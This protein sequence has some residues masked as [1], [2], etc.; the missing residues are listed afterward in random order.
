MKKHLLLF[1]IIIVL[2]LCVRMCE[3]AIP[4]IIVDDANKNKQVRAVAVI[5][6]GGTHTGTVE[7]PLRIKLSDQTG[8][9]AFGELLVANLHPLF[10]GSF[11]YTVDNTDLNTNLTRNSGSVTQLSGMASIGT[12]ITADSTALLRSKQHG[13]YRA[14]LGGVARFTALFGTPTASTEQH[15]GIIDATSTTAT[16]INGYA[17]G[18]TGTTFGFRRWQ[19]SATTTVTQANWD[20]PLDGSGNSGMTI[21]QT[22][23]NVFFI[24]YQYLGA[25]AIRLFVEDDDTGFLVLVHTIDYANKNTEPSVHNPN[26]FMT[27][28]VSNVGTT[29]DITVRSSSYMYAVEGKTKFIEIHQTS[30]ST[31]LRQKTTVTSEIALFTIRNRATFAGKTN[32]IDI[33]LKHMSASTQANAANARGS[34]RLVKNATLGGSPDYNK[35]STD[36]SVIEIDV[37]G[38]TVTDGINIIPISL[39]GR[40]AAGS[41]LLAPLEIILNPNDTITFA[42]QS[43]NSSTME[44]EL[45]WRELWYYQEWLRQLE[46]SWL[47]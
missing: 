44:G 5:D 29:S 42:V 45:L 26:F 38:T 36:T 30:N 6:E 34:A 23:L 25:G 43:S 13:R 21:D 39:A 32:F 16:F 15:V 7:N 40:D 11:E 41:E 46:N 2:G 33:L 12:G 9:T 22:K 4:S 20:D 17:V 27:Y 1:G 14:G 24:Q 31:G 18:Y 10:Q 8:K 47:Q 19:N 37:A 28:F 35:I 3:A